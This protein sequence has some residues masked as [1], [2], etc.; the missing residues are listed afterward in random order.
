[1][2]ES[3][4]SGSVRGVLSNEHPYREPR[5]IADLS[6]QIRSL[7]SAQPLTEATSITAHS[8]MAATMAYR[9]FSGRLARRVSVRITFRH[10]A[11]TPSAVAAAHLALIDCSSGT[12]RQR[13]RR[14]KRAVPSHGY[15]TP[16]RA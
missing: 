2:L 5:P 14:S 10:Q 15:P 7:M 16:E 1:M 4:S 13:R 8:S 11:R 9:I 3:G 6:A 12:V